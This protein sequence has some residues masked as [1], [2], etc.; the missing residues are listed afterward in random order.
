MRDSAGEYWLYIVT[1]DT[2]FE[3][4]PATSENVGADF[5][6]KTFLTLSTGEKIVS[7]QFHKQSM[8]QLRKLNKA[9]SRKVKGSNNWYR[10]IRQLARLYC[11]ISNQRRDWHFKLA[12]DLCRRFDTIATETLNIDGMKRLWEEKYRTWLSTSSFRF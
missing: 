11:Q 3:A 2:T 8:K 1:D 4:L 5:G 7:P 9:V 12:T 6:L 10:A